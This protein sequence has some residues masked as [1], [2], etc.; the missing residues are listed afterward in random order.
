MSSHQSLREKFG[1]DA[2][3]PQQFV[4]F[5]NV[6]WTRYHAVAE[7]GR[8][9]QAS[10][11]QRLDE[12]DQWTD[13]IKPGGRYFFERGGTAMVAFAV[14]AKY[15]AGNGLI[16]VGT[17]TDSP[18]LRLKPTSKITSQGVLQMGVQTYGGGLWSTWFD[19]DLS[20]AGSVVLRGANGALQR[21]LL[22]IARPICRVPMLAVHLERG[23]GTK[24]TINTETHLPAVLATSIKDQLLS[25]QGGAGEGKTDGSNSKPI[26]GSPAA[27]HHPVLLNLIA[28]ELGC[29]VDD[30]V[31]FDLELCDTQPSAI[32]GVHNEFIFSG[33][34]DN[35]FSVYCATE[36]L[37]SSSPDE[38]SLADESC[39]HGMWV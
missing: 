24:I 33:R 28:E 18:H 13:L 23:T 4:D 17:H 11:F 36:A 38:A 15:V 9:L 35:L 30:I 25:K 12:R 1:A 21:K 8:R 27:N 5:L 29:A 6:A 7:C 22:K 10:G 3:L 31:D 19:R 16:I 37:L 20:V 26:G 2:A 34:L 14:G 39:I 32:G